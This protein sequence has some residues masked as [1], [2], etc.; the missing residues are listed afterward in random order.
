[1]SEDLSRVVVRKPWGREYMCYQS[2]ELAI[3]VLEMDEYKATSLHA[4]V[5]KNAAFVVLRGVVYLELIRG[6]ALRFRAVSKINVF[7]GRFH[8]LRADIMG[9]TLIEIESPGDKSDIVRLED[10]HG[11]A[12][13][14]YEAGGEHEPRD[15]RHAWIGGSEGRHIIAGCVLRTFEPRVREELYGL[16]D[17]EAVVTL[18]G[19]LERGLLPPGDA[20]DGV[21][22]DRLARAFAPIPGSSFLHIKEAT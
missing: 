16:S 12:G 9:A 18:H 21:T 11:R 8:R 13:Q 17:G 10:Y 22:L 7:R 6:Q 1:M 4:H 3:W 5:K 20:I 14:P 15:K 2:P 19:G